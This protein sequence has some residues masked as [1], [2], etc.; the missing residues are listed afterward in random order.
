MDLSKLS[1]NELKVLAYD[2]L[3]RIE[4]AQSNLRFINQ[5][6]SKKDKAVSTS[7]PVKE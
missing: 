5:E 2:E 3:V 1:L 6:I 7:E 4:Q